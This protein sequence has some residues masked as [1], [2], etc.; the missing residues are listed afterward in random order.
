MIAHCVN[1]VKLALVVEHGDLHKAGKSEGAKLRAARTSM[2]YR[3]ARNGGLDALS[4]LQPIA[5]AVP[6]ALILH[7]FAAFLPK[8]KILEVHKFR[9]A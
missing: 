5:D 4:L 6:G 8:T 7:G 3:T 2:S 1:A 9:H